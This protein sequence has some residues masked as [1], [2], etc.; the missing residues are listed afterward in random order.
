MDTSF[1]TTLNPNIR[2]EATTKQ[3]FGRFLYKMVVFAKCGRLIHSKVTIVDALLERKER[4]RVIYNY[5]GSWW[6]RN[7]LNSDDAD[8]VLLAT[9]RDIKNEYGDKIRMRIEEPNVQIY[10]E[11]EDTLKDIA[12]RILPNEAVNIVSLPEND[13]VVPLLKD[14]AII[15]HT[16]QEYKYK[17]IFRDGRYNIQIKHQVL[18]YLINLDK[19]TVKLP[20][21][22]VSMLGNSMEYSWGMYFF[23]NDKSV[24]TFISL[25]APTLVSNI[26][27]LVTT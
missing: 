9:L 17:V 18:Q 4:N 16:P 11:D 25:I 7:R 27:E 14:G 24:V 13:E 12:I 6:Q 19:D 3:Y 26:H 20:Q 5:G 15:K 22:C 21:N 2:V 10:T 8:V 23:T 1:W